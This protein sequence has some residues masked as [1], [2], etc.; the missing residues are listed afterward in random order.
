MHSATWNPNDKGASVTLSNG[1]LTASIAGATTHSVRATLAQSAGK[2]HYECVYSTAGGAADLMVGIGRDS[3][4]LINHPGK[5]IN[6]WGYWAGNGKKYNN[7]I[8]TAYAAGFA[9]GDV[10][11][12]VYDADSG[13]IEFY[14]NGAALG[15]AFTVE[16]GALLYPM[17]GEGGLAGDDVA[18][19]RFSTSD[20]QYPVAGATAWEDGGQM[21]RA[22]GTV[23]VGANPAVAAAR[24][25][26]IFHAAD[27]AFLGET[28]SD[29]VTGNYTID[30][31]HDGHAVMGIA[32]D[33]YGDGWEANAD[34]LVGT[35]VFPLVSNAR[36]YEVEIAGSA[37]AVEP[38]WPTDG[39]TVVSGSVTFRD[40]GTMRAP[41][42]QGPYVPELV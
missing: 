16:A 7:N 42:T 34:Y 31:L 4:S 12:V 9:A 37:G 10:I 15:V 28:I 3:A 32:D 22:T 20:I 26:R 29:G 27:G 17:V 35:R 25:V 13:D 24:R 5:D 18:V 14:K 8:A 38:T 30:F 11:G 33:D 39:G 19:G 2:F 1:D 40:K 36:W 23:T 41:E 21:H 6:S